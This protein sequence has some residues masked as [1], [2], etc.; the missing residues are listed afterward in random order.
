MVLGEFPIGNPASDPVTTSFDWSKDNALVLQ[1]VVVAMLLQPNVEGL[2][3][4]VTAPQRSLLPLLTWAAVI[5]AAPAALRYVV[6]FWQDAIGG[7]TS[8]TV[9]VNVQTFVFPEGSAAVAVTDE[10]PNGNV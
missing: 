1:E 9:T 7:W 8:L 6:T 2:I 4:T 5:E 10:V 3:D